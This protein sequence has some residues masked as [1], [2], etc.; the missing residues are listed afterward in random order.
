MRIRV[1]IFTFLLLAACSISANER[2]PMQPPSGVGEVSS[3]V[4][5]EE[6]R[7]TLQ[8]VLISGQRHIAVI[9]QR[10]VEVGDSINGARVMGIYPGYVRLSKANEVFVIRLLSLNVKRPANGQ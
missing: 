6:A 1:W 5:Q 7:W 10:S 3:R 9:N 4:I 8:S 2:D